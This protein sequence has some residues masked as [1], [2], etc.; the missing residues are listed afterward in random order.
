MATTV[1]NKRHK[2]PFDV[3]VGRP[4]EW[5]NPFSHL[6]SSAA[7]YKVDSVEEAVDAF[8]GYAITRLAQDPKWLDP[9]KDKVLACWCAPK[10]CHGDVIVRLLDG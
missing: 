9:L 3:Y 6:K 10:P 5:G 8:Y 4:S 2:V 7:E 1:V